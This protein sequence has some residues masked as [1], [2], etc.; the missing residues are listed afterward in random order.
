MIL[1][2]ICARFFFLSFISKFVMVSFLDIASV[3]KV[4]EHC[5]NELFWGLQGVIYILWK[6]PDPI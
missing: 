3:L 4:I 6:W 5:N 2:A 1:I